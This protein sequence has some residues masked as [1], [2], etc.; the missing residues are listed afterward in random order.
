MLV[1]GKMYPQLVG[2]TIRWT[3]IG[4]GDLNE[5]GRVDGADLGAL[6]AAWG[7]PDQDAD[8]K[9]DGIVN[10]ADLGVLLSFWTP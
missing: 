3:S 2:Q 4:V 7:S 1:S 8:L 10:G 9:D 5:D 6:L